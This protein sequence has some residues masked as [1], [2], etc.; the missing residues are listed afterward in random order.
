LKDIFIKAFNELFDNK[1]EIIENME[2][3]IEVITDTTEIEK[4]CAELESEIEVV[5]GLI[6][7]HIEENATKPLDQEVYT[8]GYNR[9]MERYNRAKSR[10]EEL[11]QECESRKAKRVNIDR[12][13]AELKKQAHIISEFDEQLFAIGVEKM[14]V[15]SDG[16][17]T[18]V[19]R[20]G[21][22]KTIK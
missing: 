4:Q 3:A 20:D 2:I 1:D 10:L 8:D 17:L 19:F 16:G 22:R 5:T 18:V 13:M 7:K 14:V 15:H 9:L 11:A 6:Q 12:F 21:E